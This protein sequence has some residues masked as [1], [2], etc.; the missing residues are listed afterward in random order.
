MSRTTSLVDRMDDELGTGPLGAACW[1]A[2]ERGE[3]LRRPWKDSLLWRVLQKGLKA[4][5]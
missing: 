2:V 3:N 4:E 5:R 1:E